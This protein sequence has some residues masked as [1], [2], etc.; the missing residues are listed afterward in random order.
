MLICCLFWSIFLPIN[1]R[2]SLSR[3]HR[4]KHTTDADIIITEKFRDFST[5]AILFQILL[6]YF[7]S[8]NSKNGFTWNEGTAISYALMEDLWIKAP[9][10]W[11]AQFPMLC[12]VLTYSAII[13]EYLIALLIFF[14][15][16]ND[17]TRTI[18]AFFIL[19]MLWAFSIFLELGLFPLI[20]TVLAIILIPS[21]LWEKMQD[22]G[23]WKME[24]ACLPKLQRRQGKWKMLHL[25]IGRS[26]DSFKAR[27]EDIRKKNYNAPVPAVSI[28]GS[29]T[30]IP[31]KSFF[32]NVFKY[33]KTAIIIGAM[34]IIG[35]KIILRVD[36]IKRYIPYPVFLQYLDNTTLFIQFWEMYAP[37]PSITHGWVKI[38]GYT[39]HNQYLDTKSQK[40]LKDDNSDLSYYK[41]LPWMIFTY[42][43]C[44]YNNYFEEKLIE[45]WAQYEM[46][47][48]NGK[49]PDN[50]LMWVYI[51]KYTKTIS[52]P[53]NST[54]VNKKILTRY[55]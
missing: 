5:L 25:P 15:F 45:R 18:A 20:G 44:I 51:I 10:A 52:G 41:S 29:S 19:S 24:N 49:N 34:V 21:S 55:P 23:R 40:P 47:H 32:L 36:S 31:K 6:I 27:V 2:F 35:W 13:I 26:R 17:I 42:K 50:E 4:T 30:K 9:A 1:Q 33:I 54:P 12:K 16:K 7:L 3:T 8:A 43:T 48:W 28:V 46:N 37:N 53:Q 22:Y 38:A 14:P 11:L 39:Q